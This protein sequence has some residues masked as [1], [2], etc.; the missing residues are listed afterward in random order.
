MPTTRRPSDYR[1]DPFDLQL[2]TSV[3]EHGTITAAAQA[4]SLSLAAASARVKALEV[5]VG[6]KLL[7]RS[8]RGVVVTDAGQALARQAR[9]VLSSLDALHVEVAA[10]GQGLRGSVRMLC[11][12][13]ALAEAL[14]QRIGRFLLEHPDIDLDL[15]ELSS[16][17]VLESLRQ[18]VAD[19]GIVADHV[20]TSGLVT[21]P[22]LA[23]DLVALLPARG[24]RRSPQGLRFADLLDRPFVGLAAESGLSRFLLQQA[25]RSGRV[26]QHRVRLSSFDAIAKVVAA[27]VGVAVVPLSAANRWR[28]SHLHVVALQD[29][30]ANRRLL[31]C[32]TDQATTRPT[33]KA[34]IRA[35]LTG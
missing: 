26:P 24:R 25:A 1:I 7:V 32:S 27:G 2:F 21:Q 16:E 22:W 6:V 20:D 5:R 23:D 12:T 14:P 17:G 3:I 30:W 33:T 13:S 8:K 34:L 31:I 29:P 9:R 15:R 11:N 4:M 18:G 10:F 28:D 19:M 35:L